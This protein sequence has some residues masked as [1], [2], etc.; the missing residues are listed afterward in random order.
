MNILNQVPSNK[1]LTNKLTSNLEK[2]IS[3]SLNKTAVKQFNNIT[4]NISDRAQ[5]SIKS[6]NS[7]NFLETF[8]NF[9][10]QATGA[11]EIVSTAKNVIQNTGNL[12]SSSESI[13][14]SILDSLQNDKSF[15][16][17][18]NSLLSALGLSALGANEGELLAQIISKPK[19]EPAT[20]SVESLKSNLQAPS[21]TASKPIKETNYT[22]STRNIADTDLGKKANLIESENSTLP[23]SSLLAQLE[24]F[25]FGDDGLD[26]M[27]GFDAVN[28]LHHIPLV[29][30]I[31]QETSGDTLNA[32]AK[33][34]GG[35]IYGGALGL[36]LSAA[37]L[38]VK[39]VTGSSVNETISNFDYGKL[40][41]ET[42][43]IDT[44]DIPAI[45]KSA[46]S[47]R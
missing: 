6:S 34:G 5:E 13:Q 4:N 35:F 21:N 39:Y 18:Q 36:A 17:E 40:F 42:A 28:V 12:K 16:A 31:Y 27:D 7:I 32:V 46:A 44:N 10:A 23:K 11:N 9:L 30:A 20:S 41:F 8:N 45:I 19:S 2:N 15:S 33:L 43:N 1:Q 26:L 22:D 29:S 14:S 24:K 37:D 3:S 38:A 47:Y 25:S